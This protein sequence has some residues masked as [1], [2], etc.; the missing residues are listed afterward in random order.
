[1]VLM[2]GIVNKDSPT[3]IQKLEI[4]KNTQRGYFE[5]E[6][7]DNFLSECSD[8]ISQTADF[9][10]NSRREPTSFAT[11]GP[12]N[13]KLGRFL[14]VKTRILELETKFVSIFFVLQLYSN[15]ANNSRF[16]NLCI[17][18]TLFFWIQIFRIQIQVVCSQ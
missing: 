14:F 18:R 12:V 10:R 7:P 3:N 8:K 6:F 16:Y 17:C 13:L 9:C 2:F 5:R 15:K 11:D 4:F 1:M